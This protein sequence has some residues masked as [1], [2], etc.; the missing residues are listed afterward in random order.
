MADPFPEQMAALVDRIVPGA[1]LAHMRRLSGGAS[2]ETWAFEAQGAEVAQKLILRRGT[3]GAELHP[4]VAGFAVEAAAIRAAAAQG[5]PCPH[6]RHELEPG[7]RLGEGFVTDHVDGET[8]ARRIQRDEE[9]AAAR[10]TLVASFG[11][12]LAKVHRARADDLPPM[13]IAGIAQTLRTI[14]AALDADPTAR[15]V[16][17]L[18]LA[19]ATRNAPPEPDQ[20]ALIHGDFRLGNMIVGPNGIGALLDWELAHLGDPAEDLAW[21]SLPP[22]RF[23]RMDQPVAGLGQRAALFDAYTKV[24]GEVIDPARVHWWEVMGSLRWGLFCAEMLTRFR[25][26]DPSVERGMIVRRISESE[27]DLLAAIEGG[28]DAR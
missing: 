1:E 25:S 28:V 3:P 8:L 9:F 12:I 7:D 22:W 2:Q 27:I 19:W 16:F 24:S 14:R 17:E 4:M 15:P 21:I 18:A 13:R 10:E 26:D 11:A 23:G 5:V 20:L 6:I